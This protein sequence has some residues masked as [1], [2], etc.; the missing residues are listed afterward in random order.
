MYHEGMVSKELVDYIKQ[1]LTAG[2]SSKEI[3]AD[4]LAQGGW[5][6]F[7]IDEAFNHVATNTPVM[8]GR[9]YGDRMKPISAG[10]F[11][12]MKGSAVI[13]PAKKKTSSLPLFLVATFFFLLLMGIGAYTF[14]P[15]VVQSY[16]LD[17]IG[18]IQRL[19]SGT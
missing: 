13:Q 19:I 18:R 4:L 6:P 17:I 10:P 3:E 9:V 8:E 11:P 14:F 1:R 15:D 2:H 12:G 7:D 16:A 5:T